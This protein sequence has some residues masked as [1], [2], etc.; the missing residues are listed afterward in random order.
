M[1][2]PPALPHR[3]G[4]LLG[5]G[6][7]VLWGVLPLYFHLLKG[8]PA[9]QVLS[10]RVLWSLLLLAAVVAFLRKIRPIAAAAR[11]R[12][13]LLLLAS[14]LLIATNWLVYIWAVQHDHVL[15][16]SLGYFINPLV[17]VALGVV[18]LGEKLR[19]W[20]VAAIAIA[21]TGVLVLALSG[22]G[23]LWISLVLALSFGFYGLVRKVA[24][25]DALG[26]LTV[27]TLIL[28]PL[29]AGVILQASATGHNSFGHST[30]LDALLVAAG[31]ITAAPLLMFAAA[32]RRMPYATL[33]LL[34]YI[35]PSLQFAEAVLLFGE[36]IRPVHMVTFALIWTGCALYAWDSLRA[37][38]QAQPAA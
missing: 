37:A 4:L 24:A 3:N 10:H 18:V 34:Q 19:R 2:P 5:I 31:A 6:A 14:A 26:G 1:T 11:G 13:L 38:R 8:V 22:A 28:A 27:E 35:A 29:A 16:S 9:E 15:E 25:I 36:P 30:S 20:Q 32:A 33:G 7:Y 21:A 17:N 12:T 23:A